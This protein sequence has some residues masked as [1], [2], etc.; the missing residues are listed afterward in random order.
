MP[1]RYNFRCFRSFTR[2]AT[3]ELEPFETMRHPTTKSLHAYWE[4]L[5]AGRPAPMRGD[6]EPEDIRALLP[7]VFILARV[8]GDETRFRLAGDAVCDLV[9]MHLN[10]MKAVSMWDEASR[11]RISQ[12]IEGVVSA[13]A[14]AT[15]T[16]HAPQLGSIESATAEF[17]FLP[18]CSETG[19]IDRIIGSATALSGPDI[20]RGDSPRHFGMKKMGLSAIR[21]DADGRADRPAYAETPE[22]AAAGLAEKEAP[23]ELR[24]ID[25]KFANEERPAETTLDRGRPYLRVVKDDE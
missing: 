5:R 14:T 13:P 25:G 17:C 19:A 24:A 23:F 21:S 18:L 12:L 7:N 15:A 3:A 8:D 6:V 4:G 11:G 1:D 16:G 10:R 2:H 22:Y 20:W 9:G